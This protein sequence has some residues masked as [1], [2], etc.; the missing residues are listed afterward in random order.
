M[1]E[2]N[3]KWATLSESG[4][5]LG[6]S[7]NITK[8]PRRRLRLRGGA[9]LAA[10]GGIPSAQMHVPAAGA[11]D[12]MHNVQQQQRAISN[13]A[14]WQ[15]SNFNVAQQHG[16]QGGAVVNVPPAGTSQPRHPISA[17]PA[18]FGAAVAGGDPAATMPG[19]DDPE[20]DD[21]YEIEE[22]RASRRSLVSVSIRGLRQR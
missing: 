9:S 2:L 8:R 13:A 12:V 22:I 11:E 10:S 18:H 3:R 20:D 14:A 19:L 4:S 16:G 15:A 1:Y 7:Q 17:A 21:Y 6:A 5:S